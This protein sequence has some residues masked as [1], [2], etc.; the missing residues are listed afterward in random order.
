[1]VSQRKGCS[2]VV[3]VLQVRTNS[4][5]VEGQVRTNSADVQGRAGS[6]FSPQ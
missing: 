6:G 5:V 2:E 1:M 4:A 3:E